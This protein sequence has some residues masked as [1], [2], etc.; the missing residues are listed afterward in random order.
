VLRQ[1]DYD[2]SG[3]VTQSITY[4]I[5]LQRITQI[6]TDNQGVTQEYYFTFDGHGST[7]VLTD[8]LGAIVQYAGMGQVFHYDAYG[9]ALG[10]VMANALTEFL[11]S[12]EQFD[13]KIG[14]QYLRARYYDPATGRFNRLD[15][16]FGNL[17]DPQSFHNYLYSHADPS[18]YIDPSGEVAIFWLLG[19]MLAGG[20]IGGAISAFDC[21]LGGG[22]PEDIMYA[23]LWGFGTGVAI[24]AL[25]NPMVALV[26]TYGIGANATI[27]SAFAYSA[28]LQLGLAGAAYGIAISVESFHQGKFYQGL[29]RLSTSGVGLWFGV[30]GLAKVRF[31][32]GIHEPS[33]LHDNQEI[34]AAAEKLAEEAALYGDVFDEGAVLAIGDNFPARIAGMRDR[35]TN[36][37]I[38]RHTHQK[39]SNIPQ[40]CLDICVPYGGYGSQYT[41]ST[42]EI[43]YPFTPPTFSAA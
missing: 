31:G 36:N 21:Y 15:P 1:T 7:R 24:G 3:A 4:I 39:L 22:S 32:K 42:G 27:G 43:M 30:R 14:Q 16:F 38:V 35:M 41:T 29:F 5:G 28:L 10:F 13:A 11:Y 6:V 18:N 12:G 25:L 19:T 9:N 40:D 17:S 2:E 26:A 33:S 20:V 8:A 34:Y 37:S 23:G